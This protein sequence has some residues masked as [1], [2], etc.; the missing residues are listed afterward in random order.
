MPS[1]NLLLCVGLGKSVD[2]IIRHIPQSRLFLSPVP[3]YSVS[4]LPLP[5]PAW[6]SGSP[7]LDADLCKRNVTSQLFI[8][9][10]RGCGDCSRESRRVSR[11]LPP[12]CSVSVVSQFG[13]CILSGHLNQKAEFWKSRSWVWLQTL[14]RQKLKLIRI[15]SRHAILY[16]LTLLILSVENKLWITL[17]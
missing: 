10:Y 9:G 7:V 16:I 11:P 17:C 5:P 15:N 6:A 4:I 14:C 1:A 8:A 3:E 2:A 12:L 13:L